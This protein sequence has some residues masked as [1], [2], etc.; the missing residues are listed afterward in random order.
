LILAAVGIYG[1]M[2]YSVAQRTHEIG[3]RVA[4]GAQPSDV[5]RLV[6]GQGARLTMAGIAV[7]VSVAL[8]LTRFMGSFL[9]GVKASDPLTFAGVTIL[10]SCIAL[11][12]CYIPA[13]RAMRIDPMEALRF[14]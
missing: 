3:T 11:A 4:L 12:A 6:L 5:L 9:F 10:L 1:V 8:L 2:A 14:D 13:R 7:G